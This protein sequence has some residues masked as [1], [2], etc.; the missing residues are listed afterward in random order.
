MEK[1][2]NKIGLTM[3]QMDLI[4][5]GVSLGHP[6]AATGT[7]KLATLIHEMEPYGQARGPPKTYPPTPRL[8]WVIGR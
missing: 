5:V 1:V 2:L 8:R 3:D 7:A 6:I 4:T